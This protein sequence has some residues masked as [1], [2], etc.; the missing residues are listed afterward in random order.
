[1]NDPDLEVW[2][3]FAPFWLLGMAAMAGAFWHMVHLAIVHRRG[4]AAGHAPKLPFYRRPQWHELTPEGR[5]H[6]KRALIAIVIFVGLSAGGVM[7][8]FVWAMLRA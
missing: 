4:Q 8:G 7:A 6:F 5:H 2:L 1:M 3:L